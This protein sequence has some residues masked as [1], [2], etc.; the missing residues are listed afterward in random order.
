MLGGGGDNSSSSSSMV[1]SYHVEWCSD[2]VGGA[3]CE[4]WRVVNG[5]PGWDVGERG[6]ICVIC[7]QD[8][9]GGE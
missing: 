3:V 2:K 5:V 6:V 7:A 8:R 1:D 4:G 9:G